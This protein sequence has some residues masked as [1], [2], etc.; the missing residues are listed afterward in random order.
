MKKIIPFIIFFVITINLFSQEKC[1]NLQKGA[2]LYQLIEDGIDFSFQKNK[3]QNKNELEVV[4]KIESDAVNFALSYLKKTIKQKPNTLCDSEAF[5]YSGVLAAKLKKQD[6]A[7]SFLEQF[8]EQNLIK[9]HQEFKTFRETHKGKAHY[10]LAKIYYQK[11]AYKKANSHIKNSKDWYSGAY[12]QLF[13]KEEYLRSKTR[14]LESNIYLKLKKPQTAITHLFGNIF[15]ANHANESNEMIDKAINIVKFDLNVDAFLLNVDNA[16]LKYK[17][18][19]FGVMTIYSIEILDEK[20]ELPFSWFKNI[21]D[22]EI[23]NTI[24]KNIE[25]SFFYKEILKLVKE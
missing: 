16:I 25:N 22:A 9:K 10:I 6:D 23:E 20:I 4:T 1:K 8:L 18:D 21:E 24:K 12:S 19:S 5:F 3:F 2:T 13:D 15:H 7:I 14:I 11:E 17:K